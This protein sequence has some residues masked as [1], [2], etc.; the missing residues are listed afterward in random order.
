MLAKPL[1]PAHRGMVRGR[2]RNRCSGIF[3]APRRTAPRRGRARLGC[4]AVRGRFGAVDKRDKADP[5]PPGC[6]RAARGSPAVGDR[7]GLVV[8]QSVAQF[9]RG[10]PTRRSVCRRARACRRRR[11][12]RG[13][14]P[15][16]NPIAH[17][18]GA[19]DCHGG[20]RARYRRRLE[21]AFLGPCLSANP[22]QPGFD[23]VCAPGFAGERL[24]DF[25]RPGDL[26]NSAR[27]PR[28][29]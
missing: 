15:P 25:S 11:S 23:F 16:D 6:G 22:A 18:N 21:L 4:G 3:S 29:P 26:R 14:T 17:R 7:L 28:R 5:Q 12:G 9:G 27:E 1:C 8:G 24:I 10:G 2:S 20:D 13:T 19:R